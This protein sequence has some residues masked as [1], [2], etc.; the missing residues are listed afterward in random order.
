MHHRI[1]IRA[2][3]EAKTMKHRQSINDDPPGCERRYGLPRHDQASVSISCMKWSV[4]DDPTAAV[5]TVVA[6]LATAAG[7]LTDARAILRVASGMSNS[8]FFKVHLCS[9]AEAFRRA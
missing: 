4:I 9:R 7:P 8:F 6:V 1:R 5:A 2:G 3:V